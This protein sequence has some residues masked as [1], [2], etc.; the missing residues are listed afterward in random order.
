[1][2]TTSP[3]PLVRHLARVPVPPPYVHRGVTIHS[4]SVPAPRERLQA[5]CDAWF[6]EPTKGEVCYRPL[7]SQ[8]FV[9]AANIDEIQPGN[10]QYAGMG[11][12]SE[13]DVGLWAL[14][15]R[16]QPFSL[17][18]RWLPI[19]LLVD[20]ADAVVV[21]REV[22][23]FQKEQ[24]RLI[25]PA[26]APSPGP[27]VVQANVTEA[28]GDRL[29]W[30]E[31]IRVEAVGE[32]VPAGPPDWNTLEQATEAFREFLLA[33][34]DGA[35]EGIAV[36]ATVAS[37]SLGLP[38]FAFLKQVMAADGTDRACYQ[39]VLEGHAS[40]LKFRRGGFTP[41]QYQLQISSYYSHPFESILGIG[42]QTQSVG[43]A[44]WAQFDFTVNEGTV[45]HEHA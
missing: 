15:V 35:K 22:Y 26:V 23:G 43:R 30:K 4:F 28:E 17:V 40:L 11:R 45:L 10:P 2:P 8:I 6:K 20:S 21:G 37:L 34:S 24:G 3:P 44:V 14:V 9:L 18:P 1:M 39:A 5:L 16:T 27:F 12:T 29:A 31:M 41:D 7:L 38:P 36:D 42:G 32:P 33:R 25:V 19:R 13:V